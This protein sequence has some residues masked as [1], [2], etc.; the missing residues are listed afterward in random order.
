ML[1]VKQVQQASK[2]LAAASCRCCKSLLPLA[3]ATCSCCVPPARVSHTPVTF[4]IHCLQLLHVSACSPTV[5]LSVCHM[6]AGGL[7]V[8]PLLCLSDCHMPAV[9]SSVCLS[10]NVFV[11]PAGCCLHIYRFICFFMCLS[12][13]QFICFYICLSVCVS[14][15]YLSLWLSFCLSSVCQLDC[16]PVYFSL[17]Q[18]VY[19]Y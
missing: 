15:L 5:C 10:C 7:S 19:C 2:L 12:V 18:S 8:C 11:C 16:L 9:C 13:S 17:Y 6:L 3:L 14:P 4:R 1:H